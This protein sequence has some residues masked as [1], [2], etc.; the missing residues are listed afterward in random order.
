MFG[1]FQDLMLNAFDMLLICA[2]TYKSKHEPPNIRKGMERIP[3][4]LRHL[5]IPKTWK[6][7]FADIWKMESITHECRFCEGICTDLLEWMVFAI[8][9]KNKVPDFLKPHTRIFSWFSFE[10]HRPRLALWAM[11]ISDVSSQFQ[12]LCNIH[13]PV[14]GKVSMVQDLS[15]R[16]NGIYNLPKMGSAGFRQNTI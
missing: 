3:R 7:R 6:S 11:Q 1:R 13:V 2:R 14:F 15:T 5:E 12:E 4:W 10:S 8:V 9:L 16:I